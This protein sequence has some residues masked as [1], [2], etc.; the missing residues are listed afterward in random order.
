M[1]S[2]GLMKQEEFSALQD[3]DQEAGAHNACFEWMTIRTLKG[4]DAGGLREDE[5]MK[6]LFFERLSELRGLY[7]G[8]G[9]I[10]DGRIPVSFS[11][12]HHVGG[13]FLLSHNSPIAC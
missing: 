8:V 4:I 13:D 11:R 9:S 12:V 7:E 2:W 5:A 1:L 10:I 6:T 3:I